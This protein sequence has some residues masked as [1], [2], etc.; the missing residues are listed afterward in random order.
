MWADKSDLD[1]KKTNIFIP[2]KRCINF[3]HK[4]VLVDLSDLG[5]DLIGFWLAHCVRCATHIAEWSLRVLL[6]GAMVNSQAVLLAIQ[7][8]T[9][10]MV[11][12]TV[13][14]AVFSA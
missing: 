1:A 8:K 12:K 7:A 14:F 5:N 4:W 9:R 13:C 2:I 3:G 10:Q 6:Q 11:L